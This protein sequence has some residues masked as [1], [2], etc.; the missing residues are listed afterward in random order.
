[1]AAAALGALSWAVLPV[2]GS[3]AAILL[4]ERAEREIRQSEGR[5]SGLQYARVGRTAG[6]VSLA[7]WTLIGIAIVITNHLRTG[8]DAGLDTTIVT[9]VVLLGLLGWG[10][11]RNLRTR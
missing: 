2:L 8:N 3:I 9:G 1:V 6:L 5:L 4:A 7:F 10:I 11:W